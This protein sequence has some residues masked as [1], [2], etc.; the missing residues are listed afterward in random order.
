MSPYTV[1]VVDRPTCQAETP[2]KCS[3]CALSYDCGRVRSGRTF[4]W[5]LVAI[6]LAV[7]LAILSRAAAGL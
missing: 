2:A 6:V 4:S 3:N 5:G 1:N 7:G